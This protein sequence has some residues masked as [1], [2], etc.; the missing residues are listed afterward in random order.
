MLPCATKLDVVP[1]KRPH[2]ACLLVR[3]QFVF[4]CEPVAC[5]GKQTST[6]PMNDTMVGQVNLSVVLCCGVLCCVVVWCGVVWEAEQSERSLVEGMGELRT[7]VE[8][9]HNFR[10]I[11]RR[12]IEKKRREKKEKEKRRKKKKRDTH[13]HQTWQR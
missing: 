12:E 1:C 9:A 6:L 10:Q 8:G 13:K 4:L 7:I 5:H 3:V 2:L 11:D